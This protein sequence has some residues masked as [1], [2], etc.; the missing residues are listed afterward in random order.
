MHKI[1]SSGII[2]N[3]KLVLKLK[4]VTDHETDALLQETSLEFLHVCNF[5]S[6]SAFEN[7]TFGKFDL[8]RIA[9]HAAMAKYSIP[10]QLVIRA[11]ANVCSS[12]KTLLTQIGNHNAEVERFNSCCKPEDR[13]EFRVL[14]QITF[15][16]NTSVTFDSRVMILD[17]DQY[18]VSLR[19]LSKRVWIAFQAGE[20]RKHLLQYA[21]GQADLKRSGKDWYL[22]QTIELPEAETLPTTNHLGVDVGICT[23]A[24]ATD[25]TKTVRFP[26]DRIRNVRNHYYQL[27]RG[28][29]RHNT[30]SSRK[31]VRTLRDKESRRVRDYNHLISRRIVEQ[32][33]RTNSTIVLEDLEGIREGVKVTKSQRRERFSWAYAQLIGFIVYKAQLEGIP[34]LFV[35]PDYTSKTCSKCY[36][37]A[38]AN[39]TTQAWFQCRKCGF[40]WHADDN[41]AINIRFLGAESVRQK[42]PVCMQEFLHTDR[43]KPLRSRPG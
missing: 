10:S 36:Y 15:Q 17:T 20:R 28:L 2:K 19:T 8:Q 26:G 33:K 16:P 5:L 29:Q 27:R 22:F 4:L 21:G 39:R 3:M 13:K 25:G 14:T 18:R 9:Y 1:R 37:M 23:V 35:P 41:A 30:K 24:S 6:R 38:D 34:V 40:C 31:R 32:A 42:R 11:I 12:Y 43:R 7:Q